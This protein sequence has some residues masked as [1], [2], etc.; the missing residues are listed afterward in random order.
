[1]AGVVHDDVQVLDLLNH[2][3][4]RPLARVLGCDVEFHHACERAFVVAEFAQGGRM[5][6][7]V[8]VGS[9][10][11]RTSGVQRERAGSP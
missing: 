4:D 8:A 2:R 6:L 10:S 9:P 11:R 1:M 3:C 7:V 5:F